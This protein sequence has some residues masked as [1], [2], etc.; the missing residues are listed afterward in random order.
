VAVHQTVLFSVGGKLWSWRMVVF[1]KER[2]KVG[3]LKKDPD[4]MKVHIQ[5]LEINECVVFS[6]LR[7]YSASSVDIQLTSSS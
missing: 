4:A 1:G 5:K 3:L 2:K 6:S 7:F